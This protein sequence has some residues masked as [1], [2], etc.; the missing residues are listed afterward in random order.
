MSPTIKKIEPSPGFLI[1][2]TMKLLLH[3]CCAP[4]LIYPLESLKAKHFEVTAFFYNPNIHPASEYQRRKDAVT[5]LTCDGQLEVDYSRYLPS[6]FTHALGAERVAPQRCSLCWS[7]RL[8]E[9]AKAAKFKK[10]DAFTT[11]LLVSPYQN[12]EVL[13]QIGSDIAQKN[14]VFFYYEDFRPGFRA[15]HA[16]AKL[17][18]LYC[19]NY[20]GCMYSEMERHKDVR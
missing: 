11:T 14:N 5:S 4:C 16:Q 12:Q 19:Q 9:T 13:K 1:F 8:E 15:A 2:L 20:C 17:Q 6:E 18:G 7:L 3:T 10:F